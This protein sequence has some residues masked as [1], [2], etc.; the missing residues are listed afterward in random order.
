MVIAFIWLFIAMGAA[1][2]IGVVGRSV[3]GLSYMSN[4]AAENIFIDTATAFLP[5]ILAGFACAGILAASISSSDS[6]LLISTS[7][8]A[9]NIYHGVFKKNA[10]LSQIIQQGECD[11]LGVCVE[12]NH[13]KYYAVDVAFHEAGL[14]YGTREETVLKVIAKS[15]RTAFCLYG[16]LDAKDGDVVLFRFNV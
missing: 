7:A 15:V 9:E 3:A 1:V 5:P 14:N 8:V 6:Y 16:Y 13:P 10:S 12:N 4:A 11:V 2:F